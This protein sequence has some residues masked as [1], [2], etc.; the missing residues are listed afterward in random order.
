MNMVTLVLP[1][2]VDL[3][4]YFVIIISDL[5]VSWSPT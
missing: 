4:K 1:A 5:T 3:F 2:F